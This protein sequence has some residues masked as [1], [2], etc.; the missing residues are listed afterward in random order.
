VSVAAAAERQAEPVAARSADEVVDVAST[1]PVW[2][3]DRSCQG[4]KVASEAGRR[5]QGIRPSE[6]LSAERIADAAIRI[7]DAH[8]VAALT[9]PA[10][11]DQLGVTK[12]AVRWH[13]GDR[14]ALTALVGATWMERLVPP[15]DDVS[16]HLWL[17]MFAYAY[18]TAAHRQ[19]GVARLVAAGLSNGPVTYAIP[20][21]VLVQ[22]ER[23]GLSQ[24]VIVHAYNAVIAVTI[25]FVDLE[26]HGTDAAVH[27]SLA[28][29]DAELYPA[30]GRNAD[31]LGRGA[32][33]L[34]WTP[35]TS[36]LEGSFEFLVELTI[37]GLEGLI[38]SRRP[39]QPA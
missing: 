19:P 22:L 20:N 27:R 26:L 10:V 5:T 32:L 25:G 30:I 39:I 28:T 18:R 34:A 21:A 8:G 12:T 4:G 9:A 1:V 17:R 35:G 36:G 38:R 29:V 11:A 33:G 31:L 13:V 7:V 37:G 15:P 3:D 16:W 23:S 6:P 2:A 24:D 14:Q